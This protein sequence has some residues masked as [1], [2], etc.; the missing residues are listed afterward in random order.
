MSRP[1]RI[2]MWSGP[3]NIS[4]ALMRAWEN[5]PDTVVIDEPFYAHYL[6]TTGIDHPGRDEI[7]AT[8]PTDWPTVAATLT[9]GDIG[10]A[11]I[12]YQKHMAHHLLDGMEGGWLLSLRNV[13][14]VREPRAMLTSLAKVLVSPTVADTGLP[15]QIRLAKWLTGRTGQAPSVLDSRRI[16]EDPRAGLQALCAAVDVPYDPAML[17][18]PA[19]P[20]ASDGIWAKHWYAGVEASTGFGPYRPPDGELPTHL[21]D[22][23]AACEDLYAEVQSLCRP[24]HPD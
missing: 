3:R 12:H 1:I 17:H 16:L 22:V 8:Q 7:V 24:V 5:R 23:F 11:A 15:Q 6:V 19:G 21:E 13:L 20:R 10:G 2:G 4:T 18:W 14:L 9:G